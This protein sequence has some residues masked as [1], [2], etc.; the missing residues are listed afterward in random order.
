TAPSVKND[1]E[2]A[3]PVLTTVKMGWLACDD[4]GKLVAAAI[5]S[6]V[7]G[8]RYDIS[9][10]ESPTGPELAEIYSA[11]LGREIKYRAMPPKEMGA[12]IDKAFGEGVGDR[13]AQMYRAEQEDP[14]PEPKFHDMSS[15]LKTFP[16]KMTTT[17]EWV[18][19]KREAFC[20]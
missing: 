12:I 16:V 3:Y 9:G 11:A 15:V 10:V 6:D 8:K 7:S 18:S 5:T 2:V 20:K 17:K 14:N 1:D 4:V 13:I 19:Q